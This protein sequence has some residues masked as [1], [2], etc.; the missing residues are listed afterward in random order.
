MSIK[1]KTKVTKSTVKKTG[2]KTDGKKTKAEKVRTKSKQRKLVEHAELDVLEQEEPQST[3]SQLEYNVETSFFYT[4]DKF[5]NAIDNDNILKEIQKKYPELSDKNTD[6][7]IKKSIL[8]LLDD[9]K[10]VEQLL[11]YYN[12]SVFDLF[13]LLYKMFSSVFKGMYLVKVRKTIAGK[14]YAT[15]PARRKHD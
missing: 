10:F 5:I 11:E 2:K 9:D 13:K 15:L 6:G 4:S 3:N 14:K 1:K 8:K 7:A 12:L